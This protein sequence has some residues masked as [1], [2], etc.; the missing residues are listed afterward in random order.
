[1][2]FLFAFASSLISNVVHFQGREAA[3]RNPYK[4][5]RAFLEKRHHGHYRVYNLCS[6]KNRQYDPAKFDDSVACFPFQD[7][8]PP[9]FDL[10]EEFCRDVKKYLD[11]DP[12]NVA[13]IHCKVRIHLKRH[14]FVY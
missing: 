14:S 12:K 5:V 8:H 1:M 13:A 6:E 3:Y 7:H 10:I 11:Q 9:A 4:Q 2:L